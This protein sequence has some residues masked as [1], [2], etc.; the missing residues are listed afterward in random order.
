MARITVV[1]DYPDF[2]EMMTSILVDLGGHEVSGFGS[3]EASGA[4]LS[5]TAPDLL[6]IDLHCA[7][8]IGMRP[9]ATGHDGG[10]ALDGLPTIVCSGDL[11]ALREWA[12]AL[13]DRSTVHVLP[14]PFTLGEVTGLVERALSAD[15][16]SPA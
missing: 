6:I 7:D 3:A 1:D 16:L 11:V 2:V 13:R 14:K 4:G 10:A 9:T 5:E 8:A 12:V 15:A